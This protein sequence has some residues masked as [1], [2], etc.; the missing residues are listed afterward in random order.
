MVDEILGMQKIVQ[1]P[2][3]EEVKSH[4]QFAAGTILSDGSPGVI[5]NLDSLKMVS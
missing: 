4:T 2:L 3:G 5:L 1:K